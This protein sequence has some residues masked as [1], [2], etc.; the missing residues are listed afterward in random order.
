MPPWPGRCPSVCTSPFR[1]RKPVSRSSPSKLNMGTPFRETVVRFPSLRSVQRAPSQTRCRSGSGALAAGRDRTSCP[2]RNRTSSPSRKSSAIQ[3]FPS[4][5]RKA[6]IQTAGP[7][8][9]TGPAGAGASALSPGPRPGRLQRETVS[10]RGFSQETTASSTSIHPLAIRIARNT[11][12]AKVANRG[13]NSYHPQK[14]SVVS[15]AFYRFFR[16]VF[17][18]AQIYLRKIPKQALPL[19]L[20]AAYTAPLS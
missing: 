16:K 12:P 18:D 10:T 20:M 11:F 2:L 15:A 3:S 13:Y 8:C 9:V 1:I 19:P 7:S 6:V 14:K 17:E 4:G 5:K